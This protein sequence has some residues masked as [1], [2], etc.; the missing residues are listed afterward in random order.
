MQRG[1]GSTLICVGMGRKSDPQEGET[2]EWALHLAG[3]AGAERQHTAMH[4]VTFVCMH[5]SILRIQDSR[6]S[7]R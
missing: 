5:V 1:I 7:L 4:S 3:L 2:G 6:F